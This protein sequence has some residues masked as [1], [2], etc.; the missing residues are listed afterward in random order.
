LDENQQLIFAI[1]EKQKMKKYN[2]CAQYVLVFNNL[3]N[4]Y[5]DR[6]QQNLVKLATIADQQPA[7][8]QVPNIKQPSP[9]PTNPI[10]P[11]LLQQKNQQY[12]GQMPQQF[13]Q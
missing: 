8:S 11:A 4:R 2:E 5:Q 6:L 10:H 13:R 12:L 9:P 1:I 3:T 7:L